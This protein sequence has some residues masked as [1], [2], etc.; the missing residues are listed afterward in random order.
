MDEYYTWDVCSVWHKHWPEFMNGPAILALYLAGHIWILVLCQAKI[1]LIKCMWVSDLQF[2][3]QWFCH[4]FWRLFDGLML[5]WRYGFSVTQTLNLTYICR[6][7]TYISCSSDF[8][9]YF[10]DYLIDK[11][12][13]WNIHLWCKDLPHTMYVGQWPTFHGPVIL[14]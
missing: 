1:Y 12:H 11:C 5:Y 4:I 2:M 8:A 7:L 3:V 13:N 9:L 14:S 10:E 6:S